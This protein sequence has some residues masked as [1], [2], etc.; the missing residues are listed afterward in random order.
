MQNEIMVQNRC[1]RKDFL[2]EKI[3]LLKDLGKRASSINMSLKI[4]GRVRYLLSF[5]RIR[6]K[7]LR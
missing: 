7:D 1:M 3:C 6:E 2:I 4:K 5:K